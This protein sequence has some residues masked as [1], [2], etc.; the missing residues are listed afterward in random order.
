M[1]IADHTV[2]LLWSGSLGNEHYH[3]PMPINDS[4]VVTNNL[5]L[6]VVT[7]TNV[8][9]KSSHYLLWPRVAW[10]AVVIGI[11]M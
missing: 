10:N 3:C 5:F 4:V 6:V 1:G 8:V 2:S 9:L 11:M 7:V